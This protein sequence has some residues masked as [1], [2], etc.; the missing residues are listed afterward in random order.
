MVAGTAGRGVHTLP[1]YG[2]QLL[3]KSLSSGKHLGRTSLDGHG[4]MQAPSVPYAG[5]TYYPG[6]RA[7]STTVQGGRMLPRLVTRVRILVRQSVS[8]SG[9]VTDRSI[10]PFVVIMTVRV[11]EHCTQHSLFPSHRSEKCVKGVQAISR[12]KTTLD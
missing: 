11:R 7:P 4:G 12:T 10:R 1:T 9:P 8:I 3:R 5:S 6:S 2:A